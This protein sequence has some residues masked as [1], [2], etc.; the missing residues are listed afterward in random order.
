MATRVTSDGFHIVLWSDGAITGLMGVKLAGVPVARPRTVSG[1]RRAIK[2]GW[3]FMGLVELYDLDELGG[4]YA[5]C[6]RGADTGAPAW[7]ERPALHLDWTVLQRDRNGRP[8]C[9]VAH[10]PRLRWPGMAIW[11]E[12]GRYEIMYESAKRVGFYGASVPRTQPSLRPTGFSFTSLRAA[13][14]HL[15]APET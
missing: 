11:N 5:A 15:T 1:T 3:I 8:I 4:L 2:A 6:R 7:P 13:L 14:E 9:R 12:R 10:L